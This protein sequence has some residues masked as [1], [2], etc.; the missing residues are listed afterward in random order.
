ME[1][2][3]ER[4]HSS[5]AYSTP[6]EYA[7]ACSE[8]T[9]RMDAIPPSRPPVVAS[10]TAVLAGKGPLRRSSALACCAP[11]RP[12]PERDGRLRREHSRSAGPDPIC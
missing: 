5:L 11:F 7:E 3:E 1:Y 6:R 9:G 4:P 12:K 8:L 10:R 2:N